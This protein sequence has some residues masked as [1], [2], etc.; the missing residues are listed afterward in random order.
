MAATALLFILAPL[1]LVSANT[2]S[3]PLLPHFD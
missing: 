1:L 2:Q 3:K